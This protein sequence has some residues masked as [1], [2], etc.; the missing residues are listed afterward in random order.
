[1]QQE[2]TRSPPAA[3]VAR[4]AEVPAPLPAVSPAVSPA[5][6]SVSCGSPQDSLQPVGTSA[7]R[8]L[9]QRERKA[10]AAALVAAQA[11][12]AKQPE[13]EAKAAAKNSDKQDADE[14]APHST[15]SQHQGLNT[16]TTRNVDYIPITSST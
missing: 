3:V 5:S 8:K 15:P 11:A 7:S 12:A 4:P 9:S 10:Q 16:P 14:T 2:A 6:R 1:M 13:P